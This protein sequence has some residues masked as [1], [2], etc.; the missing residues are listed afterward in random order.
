ML[1]GL[2]IHAYEAAVVLAMFSVHADRETLKG[3]LLEFLRISRVTLH[4]RLRREH[5]TFVSEV[6]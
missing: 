5:L 4:L 1:L 6:V 2:C 3:I